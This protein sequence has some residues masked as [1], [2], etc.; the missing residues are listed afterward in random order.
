MFVIFIGNVSVSTALF[1]L[2]VQ[3]LD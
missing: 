2:T 1:P 3:I